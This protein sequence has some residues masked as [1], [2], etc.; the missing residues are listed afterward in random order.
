VRELAEAF[1]LGNGA[2]LT[3]ACLLPLYPALM[4]FLAGTTAS[5]ERRAAP[6]L[7]AVVLA[8]I[9]TLMT[10]VGLV[11]HLAHAS[12]GPLLGVLLPVLYALVALLGVLMLLGVNPFTRL[13]TA[14][15][16]V[17]RNPYATA[18][19]YGLLL[20]PMTLPC[21]GPIVVSAFLLGSGS[22]AQLVDGL[23]YFA[24]FGLGV[25]WPLLVLPLLAAPLQR[26]GVSWTLRHHAT[27][28]RLSGALLVAIAVYGVWSEVLPNLAT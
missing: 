25:G 11:L 5:G 16:P 23:A 19:A 15:A 12:F 22:A 2:I 28:T 13:V 21:T 24:A 4:A 9:L 26:R 7:G 1:V 20:G 8:G 3:N 17:L 27:L 14:R 18:F 10:A 6:A